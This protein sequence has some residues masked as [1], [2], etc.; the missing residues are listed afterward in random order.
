[1]CHP[2]GSGAVVP[3]GAIH[4]KSARGELL[5]DQ[6][7]RPPPCHRADDAALRLGWEDRLRNRSWTTY[8]TTGDQRRATRIMI[9]GRNCLSNCWSPIYLRMIFTKTDS[10]FSDHAL[11]EV[12]GRRPRGDRLM[13]HRSAAWRAA[14]AF[15]LQILSQPPVPVR[16]AHS[17]EWERPIGKASTDAGGV[18]FLLD[19][20]SGNAPHTPVLFI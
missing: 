20:I 16:A 9:A 19:I 8:R 7:Q 11:G 18:F 14:P 6:R 5:P 1:V 12:L 3:R 10:H 17:D 13:P 4:W 15:G 2:F